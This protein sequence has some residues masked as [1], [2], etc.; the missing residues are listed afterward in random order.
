MMPSEILDKS[1][2]YNV[3]LSFFHSFNQLIKGNKILWI[4]LSKRP[5]EIQ[6]NM[7][8]KYCLDKKKSL[9]GNGRE[10]PYYI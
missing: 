7:T 9:K 8:R 4:H 2:Y 10:I 3:I 5:S 1:H 6:M